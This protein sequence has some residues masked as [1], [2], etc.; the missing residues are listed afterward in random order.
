MALISLWFISF[1]KTKARTK[2]SK[3]FWVSL[4][5]TC[6]MVLKKLIKLLSSASIRSSCSNQQLYN[7]TANHVNNAA[8]L[9][10][11]LW[12]K[13]IWQERFRHKRKTRHWMSED[14]PNHRPSACGTGKHWPLCCTKCVC[15]KGGRGRRKKYCCFFVAILRWSHQ[16]KLSQCGEVKWRK[17]RNVEFWT[18]DSAVH[19]FHCRWLCEEIER[20]IVPRLIS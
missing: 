11:C 10:L 2:G 6:F 1:C 5:W 4:W 15:A 17:L 8:W 12:T 3:T 20:C 14:Q 9:S 18:S 16:Y 19:P 13:P 7:D